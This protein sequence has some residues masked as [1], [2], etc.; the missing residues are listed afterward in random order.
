MEKT[1]HAMLAD[2]EVYGD[3]D[4]ILENLHSGPK[5]ALPRFRGAPAFWQETLPRIPAKERGHAA[6]RADGEEH[7]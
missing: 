3:R 6:P 2:Y 7:L 1:T 4:R 5:E